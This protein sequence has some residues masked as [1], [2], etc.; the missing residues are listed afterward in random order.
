MLKDRNDNELTVGDR[1][2]IPCTIVAI[3][4]D[5][6]NDLSLETEEVVSPGRNKVPLVI[7]SKQ[8]VKGKRQDPT[9]GFPQKEHDDLPHKHK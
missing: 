8:V 3:N 1:V 5:Q 4:A 2:Y 7:G 9:L 6:E